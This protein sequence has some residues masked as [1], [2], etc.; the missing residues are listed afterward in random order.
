MDNR[1]ILASGSP[2]RRELLKEIIS[3][4]EIMVADCDES[5]SDGI[6]PDAAVMI[7]SER[8][9]NAVHEKFGCEGLIIA[10]DTVVALDNR[11]LGK[12]ADK[13]DAFRMLRG[14]SGRSHYVY[15][16]V[17]IF[18]T[19]TD[20]KDVFFEKTEVVFSDIS[21]DEIY[22]Y[23]ESGEP[24]DKAGAYGIQGLAGKFISSINGDYYNVVGLPL[25]ALYK[26]MK[27]YL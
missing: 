4:F 15:S 12:P 23:I 26:H 18:D 7:L 1:V 11:I 14:L 5:V 25:S 20:T 24:M 3:D 17:C 21:D 22:D 6:S 13:E 8:K 10:S 9:A 16:G 27:K 2:R 19:A